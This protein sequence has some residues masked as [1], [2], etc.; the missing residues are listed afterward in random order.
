VARILVVDDDEI[1]RWMLT[2]FLRSQGHDCTPAENVVEACSH[3][4]KRSFELT[5]SDFNM[6]SQTGLDLLKYVSSHSPSTSFILISA[7]T[8]CCLRQKALEL[9]A[10]A[11][12]VKPFK[13]KE[14][15]I[16]VESVLHANSTIDLRIDHLHRPEEKGV[17]AI[18]GKQ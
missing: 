8:D 15:L 5:I 18:R 12:M 3:L 7:E 4:L 11:C 13:L 1:M 6:P 14:L 9:G 17:P 2:D 16:Q 10:V